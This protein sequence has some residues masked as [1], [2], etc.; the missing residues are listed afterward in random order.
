MPNDAIVPSA[1]EQFSYP[2]ELRTLQP[3]STQLTAL[4]NP[5]TSGGLTAPTFFLNAINYLLPGANWPT[6]SEWTTVGQGDTLAVAAAYYTT[7]QTSTFEVVFCGFYCDDTNQEIYVYTNTPSTALMPYLQWSGTQAGY[8]M[9]PN[10]NY[11]YGALLGRTF[12]P[13]SSCS[14]TSPTSSTCPQ[15][16]S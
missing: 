12:W 10:A 2:Q 8:I 4:D 6:P 15:P 14:T 1:I 5:Q 7:D 13:N 16:P 9:Y 3:L 11:I